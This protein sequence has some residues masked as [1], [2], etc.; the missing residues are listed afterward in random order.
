M[1]VPVIQTSQSV[2]LF[3]MSFLILLKNQF[4]RIF[5][6]IFRFLVPFSSLSSGIKFPFSVISWFSFDN[7]T[8]NWNMTHIGSCRDKLYVSFRETDS[9]WNCSGWRRWSSSWKFSMELGNVGK[10]I[11]Q[12]FCR[13]IFHIRF[14]W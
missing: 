3:E 10:R 14:G 5:L 11:K 13:E 12:Q 1:S 6:R 8:Q 4:R 7:A 9:V 2:F